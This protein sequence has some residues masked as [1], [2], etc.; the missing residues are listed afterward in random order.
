MYS[1]DSVA[2]RV[3]T[4]RGTNDATRRGTKFSPSIPDSGGY[5]SFGMTLF[6]FVSGVRWSVSAQASAG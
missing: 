6:V 2:E 3:V 5:C 4:W 1:V